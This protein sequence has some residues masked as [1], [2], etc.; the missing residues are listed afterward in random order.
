MSMSLDALPVG[1]C[2][3][4]LSVD[5][6]SCMRRRLY[7]LGFTAGAVARCL[8]ESPAGNPRAYALRGTVIA[9]RNGDARAVAL[10]G[11]DAFE[12]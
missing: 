3:R 8:Y 11:G 12:H 7:D 10:D 4:V 5:E 1:Q 2:A 6:R 9:L